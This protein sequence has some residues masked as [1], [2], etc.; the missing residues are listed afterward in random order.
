MKITKSQL[1][2]IILEELNTVLTEIEVSSIADPGPAQGISPD[3]GPAEPM[4]SV[5]TSK[6]KYMLKQLLGKSQENPLSDQEIAIV[7]NGLADIVGVSPVTGRPSLL[8]PHLKD[9]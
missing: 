9:F 5:K 1:K 8:P 7:R 3:V 4:L 6:L 2:Q